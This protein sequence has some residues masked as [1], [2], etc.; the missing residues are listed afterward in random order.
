MVENGLFPQKKTTSNGYNQD[1]LGLNFK[2]FLDLESGE[3]FS[4]ESKINWERGLLGVKVPHREFQC[5]ECDNSEI[6]KQ[7]EISRRKISSEC[8]IARACELLKRITQ[9][10]YYT[11]EFNKLKRLPENQFGYILPQ[12]ES[13]FKYTIPVKFGWKINQY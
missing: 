8:G 5:L 11:T 3:T 9:F 7:C 12:Y 4:N 6:C 10:K 2:N 1:I 13:D